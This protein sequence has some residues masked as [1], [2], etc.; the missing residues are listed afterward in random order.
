MLHKDLI[1]IR[2]SSDS[3]P[4]FYVLTLAGEISP[5]NVKSLKRGLESEES[6][7]NLILDYEL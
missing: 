6:R 5:A 1:L 7:I 4:R 2:D 3:N